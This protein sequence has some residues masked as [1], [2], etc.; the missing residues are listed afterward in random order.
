MY[1]L[2]YIQQLINL[3]VPD[4][5]TNSIIA[6]NKP[7][8]NDLQNV[9]DN[10]FFTYKQ[11]QFLPEWDGT[12]Q[13]KGAKV[14]YAKGIYYN[15]VE[16]N[17]NPPYDVTTWEMVSPNFIGVDNRI[18]IRGEKLILEYA[19]NLWFDT[20]FRQPPNTSDIY[21]QL[22]S[23]DNLFNFI[24]GYYNIQSSTIYSNTSNG[25]FYSVVPTVEHFG[26]TIFVPTAVH[27][28]LSSD[29]TVADNIIREF[30]NKYVACGI[31]YKIQTY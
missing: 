17:T 8:F 24:F 12:A 30:T 15:L 28:A 14:K 18:K 31:K 11:I 7:A 29:T 21:I 9:H 16:G 27:T 23:T 26:F 25:A 22:E 1:S 2:N 13:S 3:L 6:L 4:K 20:T 19:L 10:L 5:R